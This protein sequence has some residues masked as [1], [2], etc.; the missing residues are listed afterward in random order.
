MG[1]N[2]ILAILADHLGDGKRA[3]SLHQRF[4]FDVI[5]KLEHNGW[6]LPDDI[7]RD[8]CREN[9]SRVA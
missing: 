7:I 2:R 9:W 3:L 1:N 4:K 6:R 5:T 8:W